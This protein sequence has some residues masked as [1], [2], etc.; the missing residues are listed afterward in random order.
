MCLNK[1]GW[2]PTITKNYIFIPKFA[3]CVNTQL[4]SQKNVYAIECVIYFTLSQF[5]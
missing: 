5:D 1:H 2:Q 4:Y 3:S